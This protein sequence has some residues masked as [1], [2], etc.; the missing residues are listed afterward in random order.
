MLLLIDNRDSFTFN[1]AQ[2]IEALGTDV[3]VKRADG[4]TVDEIEALD[5]ERILIGPGPGH[6]SQALLSLEV[7]ER[8]AGT[9]PIF[10]LCLGCQVI[11]L[12]HGARIGP[13]TEPVHGRPVEVAHD[14]KGVFR[15][16]PSPTRFVRYNSL[17]ISDEGFPPELLVSARSSDGD[18]MAVRHP[19]LNL[20]GVLFHPESIRSE[21][22]DV[23]F[24][25]LLAI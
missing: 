8:L 12:A 10:G 24:R 5:P 9:C 23:L 6:P 19:R 17:G 25:N 20:E 11:A 16:L 22:G 14:A 2:A 1:V 13:S 3:L 21:G 18:I 4:L 15:S 7:V